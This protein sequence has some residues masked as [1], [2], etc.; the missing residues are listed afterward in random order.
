MD[1]LQVPDDG[2]DTPVGIRPHA[3]SESAN[4]DKLQPYYVEKALA[5]G[6]SAWVLNS[7]LDIMYHIF[8]NSLFPRIGDKDKVHAYMVD[9]MLIC[10]EARSSQSQPL[11]I[12]HIMWCELRFVVFN[13]KVPIYGPYLFR[14]I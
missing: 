4:K 7:F 14:L 1:L 2:L 6:K 3:N 13:I 11:D 9:M 10:E 12:S 8:R 5:N